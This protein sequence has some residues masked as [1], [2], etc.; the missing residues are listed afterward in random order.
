MTD[1]QTE[2]HH[3][4]GDWSVLPSGVIGGLLLYKGV[5]TAKFMSIMA[6]EWVAKCLNTG[7]VRA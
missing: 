6:A 1:Y 2:W 7:D 3:S 5:L 4:E